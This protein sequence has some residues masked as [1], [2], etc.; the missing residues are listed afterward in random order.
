MHGRLRA[1]ALAA[2]VLFA[3][4]GQ[5]SSALAACSDTWQANASGDFNDAGSWSTGRVPGV[6]DDACI[7]ETGTYTV[8]IDTPE[9]VRSLTV[10]GAPGT[11]TLA[12][13]GST[14]NATLATSAGLTITPQGVV[15]EASALQGGGYELISG[16]AITNAGSFVLEGGGTH[17]VEAD[18]T[19]TGTVSVSTPTAL[20]DTATTFQNEGAVTVATGASVTFSGTYAS[21]AGGSTA[22]NG[23]GQLVVSG[24][25]Y[26]QGDGTTSGNPVTVVTGSVSYTGSGASSVK[27]IGAGT[28]SG[29]IASGQSLTIAGDPTYATGERTIS[30]SF[31]NAGTIALADDGAGSGFA[32]LNGN[33]SDLITNTGTI[34]SAAGTTARF[35]YTSVL[36]QGTLAV[37]RSLTTDVGTTTLTNQGAIT[38]ADGATYKLGGQSV[39]DDTGGSIATTGSGQLVE[40]QGSYTQGAGTTTGNP[41]TVVA[42]ALAYTGAG[43]SSIDSLGAGSLSGN[44][45]SGQAL[46]IAGDPTYAT[47]E[48][49]VSASFS[50]AGTITLTDDGAGSGF[51]WL[52]G[53]GSDLLTNTGTLRS[54]A[55]TT[56]RDLYTSVLNHG[57]VAVDSTL[58]MGGGGTTFT[59]QGSVAIADG[60]QLAN[61][62]QTFVNSTAGVVSTSG[63]GQLVV[64][65][66]SFNQGAGKNTGNPVALVASALTYSGSGASTIVADGNGTL[67]GKAV[68][69][70]QTLT[71]QG[72][73]SQGNGM[74]AVQPAKMSNK[75][76][77]NLV[78]SSCGWAWL[79]ANGSTFTN[80]GVLHVAPSAGPIAYFDGTLTNNK[81]L[82][83]DAGALFDVETG[84]YQQTAKGTFKTTIASATSYGQ[85]EAAGT[86]A[87]AG[88]LAI[89]TQSP[90][91]PSVGQ[92][93]TLVSAGTRTGTWA[94]VTGRS[95]G[96]VQ[97]ATDYAAGSAGLDVR[98]PTLTLTPS[99]GHAGS[100]TTV[101]GTGFT[102]GE[103]VTLSFQDHAHVVTQL[104]SVTAAGDG[105]IAQPVTIP[106][107]AALGAGTLTAT[108]QSSGITLGKTYTV[109]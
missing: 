51:A 79:K 39:V 40:S 47:G 8:T 24:G 89:V 75:G 21:L 76:T 69:K 104:G 67:A 60:A 63:S 4:G 12:F 99:S 20:F 106:A 80:A 108:G 103:Q 5:V 30:T 58:T 2:G 23:T 53:S 52:N 84:S 16:A 61:N 32:W 77:I 11:Q 35:L 19:N 83:L 56:A 31:T 100:Q 59:N 17:Y 44:I 73:C 28:L 29:N 88:T 90:F 81:T 55:G 64:R 34:R 36:N 78:P 26:T 70:S 42:G 27:A 14:Q 57:A 62:G 46:T 85:L 37:D 86:A 72:D 74:L 94:S 54:A 105:S 43:A 92:T 95:V 87:L 6:S 93:F 13:V 49:T 107:G 38:I 68:S 7:T 82:Q 33:G 97:Y 25:T 18:V 65:S 1:L 9:S 41:V 15:D 66:G 45:A 109:N 48:R 3:L 102:S 22:I 71:I 50:N 96:G 10:G 101:G 91:V 98:A